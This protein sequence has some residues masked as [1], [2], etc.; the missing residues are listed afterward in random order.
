[1]LSSN[2][3]PVF[4]DLISSPLASRL[5]ALVGRL[6][7]ILLAGNTAVSIFRVEISGWDKRQS[8]FVEKSELYWGEQSGKQIALSK[9]LPDSLLA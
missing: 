1:L 2:K 8:F 4:I 7:M 3:T 5:H 6:G 9:K